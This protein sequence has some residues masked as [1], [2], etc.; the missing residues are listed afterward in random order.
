MKQLMLS[1][2][3]SG[4]GKTVFVC[5]LLAALKKRGVSVAA[6]KCGP[7]YIDPLF[8]ARVLGVPSRNLDLVLQGEK[9]VMETLS[10]CKADIG[11]LEGAMGFYD[12]AAGT[13]RASAWD[14]AVTTNTP[15]VLVLRPAGTA[16]TLAA[17]VKGM[18]SFRENSRIRGLILSQCKE[19][20]AAFLAPLLERETGLPVFGYLPSMEAA[21]LDSRHL[22]LLHPDEIAGMSGRLDEIARQMEKTVQIDALLALAEDGAGEKGGMTQSVPARVPARCRIAVARDAAFSFYYEDQFDRL[23]EAGGEI[24]F[25]SPLSDTV[26]PAGTDGIYLGGGYPELSAKTLSANE[27][28]RRCI[29]KAVLE[30]IPTIAEGGG[31]LYLQKTL[32]DPEGTSWPMCEILPGAGYQTRGLCRFGYCFMQARADSLLFRS[33]ERVP[34]HGFHRWDSTDRGSDFV[35]RSLRGGCW[36]EGAASPTL[37][38]AFPQLHFGGELPLAE[39]FVEA[40]RQAKTRK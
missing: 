38:A 39:R 37:Y 40:C 20:L 30:G 33:G 5:G 31:F 15:V 24:V 26:L 7:D 9:G 2:M 4:A 35:C 8:H 29:Q 11:L 13:D 22:G 23:R 12:G 32:E 14:L 34:A 18:L 27:A 16:L 28:M 1:A 25:F 6:L 36:M 3:H 10:R 19:S 21:R 17:Q